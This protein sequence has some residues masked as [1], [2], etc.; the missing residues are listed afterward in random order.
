MGDSTRLQQVVWNL[1]SNSVKFTPPD[2]RVDIT[3][4]SVGS[5]AR[6]TVRDTGKGISPDFLPYLFDRF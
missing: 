1:L 2:G 3:L 6:I 4:D 5:N